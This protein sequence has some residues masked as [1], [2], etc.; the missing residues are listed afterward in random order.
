MHTTTFSLLHLIFSLLSLSSAQLIPTQTT[1]LGPSLAPAPAPSSDL[2]NGIWLSY[3]WQSGKKLHPLN[4]L[5]KQPYS[6]KSNLIILNND[7]IELKSWEVFV[8]FQH[9]ELL[10]SATNALLANGSN[11]PALV[12]KGTVFTGFPVADLKTGIQTAGD[13]EQMM[14]NIQF[15]GTQFGVAL[16]TVPLP[17]NI[18][19]VNDG[20]ICPTPFTIGML[21]SSL[22]LYLYFINFMFM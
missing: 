17:N 6:F 16:P 13:L 4:E 2:C 21:I 19:L 7:D 1:P 8:G 10:V 20:Y 22:S 3:R 18:S 5:P 9:E 12:G 14:V 11:L 15:E